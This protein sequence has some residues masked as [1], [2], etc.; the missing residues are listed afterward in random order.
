MNYMELFE[1][2]KSVESLS[3][4]DI[5]RLIKCDEQQAYNILL[6]LGKLEH[7]EIMYVQEWRNG[8][9]QLIKHIRYNKHCI[10]KKIIK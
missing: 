3:M 7:V 2:L 10:K 8:Y 4:R 1:H 6:K 9:P 5:V